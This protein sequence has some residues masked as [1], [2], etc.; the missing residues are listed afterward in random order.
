MSDPVLVPDVAA[1]GRWR[2]LEDDVPVGTVTLHAESAL[3]AVLSVEIDPAHRGRGLA[4]AAARR[5]RDLVFSRRADDGSDAAP[6]LLRARIPVGDGAARRIAWRLGFRHDGVLRGAAG[7]PEAREVWLASLSPQ[8]PREPT[9]PWWR[10][11]VLI[12]TGVRLRA[13][14]DTDLPRVVEACSDP[15]TQHWLGRMPAPYGPEDARIWLDAIREQEARGDSVTWALTDPEQDQRQDRLLGAINLFDLTARDAEVGYWAHPEARGRG[16]MTA[17]VRTCL[18]WA[19]TAPPTGPGLTRVRATAAV[20]NA[21]SRHVLR[22]AGLREAGP[23]RIGTVLRTG[24][25]DAVRY[26]VLR[27]EFSG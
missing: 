25:S 27:E 4:S 11:P 23:E 17:A 7:D 8:D 6:A 1:T 3:V 26:D 19:F 21:A 22:S 15:R 5:A 9:T 14:R 24:P 20:E 10:P 18:A 16:L 2:V 13:V 12:G